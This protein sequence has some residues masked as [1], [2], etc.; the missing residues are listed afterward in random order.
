MNRFLKSELLSIAGLLLL[1]A[2]CSR[3]I[4]QHTESELGPNNVKETRE[5]LLTIK[6]QL[7]LDTPDTKAGETIATSAEN[8]ISTLD[9]F[10]FAADKE[11]GEYSFQERFAYRSNPSDKLP[12]GAAKLQ[13]N[14]TNGNEKETTGLLKLRKGLF[15]KLYCIANNTQIVNPANGKI[16][17]TSD[18]TPLTLS[19]DEGVNI[20]VVTLGQ[21]L[22]STFTSFHTNLLTGKIAADTL[23][24]PLTMTGALTTPLDLRDFGSASRVQVGIRLTRLVARYDIINEAGSS[25]F[26]IETVSMG[27]ARRG[28]GLFPIRPYGDIPQAKPNELITYPERHFYGDNANKGKQTGAFYSY[29]SSINDNS[30]LI[31]KGLYKINETENKEVTYRIPFNQ[32]TVNGNS[33]ALEINNNHRYTIE[34]TKAEEN[35][36]DFNI[37]I[38]NWTDDGKIDDYK[39][40]VDDTKIEVHI[41]TTD[42]ETKFDAEQNI[43]TM[44]LNPGTTFDMVMEKT[45]SILPNMTKTYAGGYHAKEY[46]WLEIASP[47]IATAT[48]KVDG[49]IAINGYK[50]TFKL[51]DGYT[52]KH[53]PRA[54]IRFTNLANAKETI[55]FVDA[56]EAPRAMSTIQNGQNNHNTFDP[57]ALKAKVYRLNNSNLQIKL[58]C[59]TGIQLTDCPAWLTPQLISENNGESLYLFTLNDVA[60]TPTDDKGTIVFTNAQY[61]EKRLKVTIL[62][63]EPDI[64]PDFTTLG[65]TDNTFT[66]ANNSTPANITMR[67]TE[68]NTFKFTTTSLEGIQLDMNFN[69]G[70]AWLKHNGDMVTRA[71]NVPN[72]IKFY[73]VND[74]LLGA[75]T[76]TITLKNK[77]TG[78]GKDYVFTV[79]PDFIAPVLTSSTHVTLAA[80]TD[81]AIPSIKITGHS[82]GGCAIVADESP[83]WLTYDLMTTDA[84][85]FTYNVSLIPGD[86]KTNFPTSL[87]SDQIIT[88]ANQSDPDKKT[89][90][91]VNFTDQGWVEKEINQDAIEDNGDY[92]VNTTGK[93]LTLAVYSMFKPTVETSYASGYGNN[94]SWL[95]APTT[96]STISYSDNRQKFTYQITIPASNGTDAAYQLHKGIITVKHGTTKIKELTIWRGASNIPYPSSRSDNPYY[97]AVQRGD[98]W[99]APINMGASEIAKNSTAVSCVGKLYQW[100]RKVG[101]T[102]NSSA[103]INGPIA[104]ENATNEFIT[105]PN[106]SNGYDWLINKNDYLWQTAKGEKTKFDPCPNGWRIPSITELGKWGSGNW[107]NNTKILTITG[108]NGINLILPAVGFRESNGNYNNSWGRYWSST[109]NGTDGRY[110]DVS[111]SKVNLYTWWRSYAFSVRCVKE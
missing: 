86:N 50:Y 96:P 108:Q 95:P 42:L 27:N 1:A 90:I 40:S 62:L 44:S 52:Q 100:G 13:L 17:E 99:W 6:N 34:I 21:P 56:L 32:Q 89:T 45:S 54:I 82:Y 14:A 98:L 65:G 16:I 10:V 11:N 63:M 26:I 87:P 30:Y 47:T 97:S 61:P 18:F 92:R 72:T 33:T 38:A 7:V 105:G 39:P 77:T 81:K 69:N 71:G 20:S 23:T 46:D 22:E 12:E 37:S 4:E 88:L 48:T 106:S 75:Q 94:K 110:A 28:S 55:L 67:V 80:T 83:Q 9:V 79:T 101:M 107:N 29:P 49:D 70:P 68:G 111:S 84:N 78:G 58:F 2:G 93:T 57:D 91:M 74:K 51:K 5:V 103:K 64:T 59:T 109:V 73:L 24:T 104:N 15:V 35:H 36:L 43:V 76:A 8:T 3:E 85:T 31:L 53:H 102:F 66:P 19:G 60:A 25:R 41:P